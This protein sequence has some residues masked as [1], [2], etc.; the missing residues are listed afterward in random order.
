MAINPVNTNRV[1][2]LASGLETDT[3]VKSM[4]ASYQSR[5]DKQNQSTTKMQ[6]K[7]DALRSVNSLIK[8][9]RES[10]MSVLN[11]SNNMLSASSY[12][13]F[14]VTMLTT[15][16]AVTIKA[17]SAALEGKM[18]IN[19]ITQ[20]AEAA[21]LDSTDVFSAEINRNAALKDLSFKTPLN[22]D[23][24][25]EIKF[26]INGASF[27][28]SQDTTLND[29]MSEI[30][31]SDAG[32]KISYSSLKDGFNIIS[33]TTGSASKIE[34]KNTSGN[35]FSYQDGEGNTV[36]GAIGIAEQT[37][38]GKD[39]MLKIDGIDV[40][41]SSNT[42]T[43]DGITYTLN[44][45]YIPAGADD[46]GISFTVK[47][48]VDTIVD[49]ISKFVDSYNE[50]VGKLQNLVGESVYRAYAPLT[51]EQ[52]DSMKEADINKW[53]EKAKSGLLHNDSGIQQLLTNVRKAL[54]TT[55]EGTGMKLSDIG[56]TTGAY[57][58]GAKITLNKDKLRTA[59]E[60][61]PD[62]VTSLFTKTSKSTD[63]SV[64]FNESGFMARI[65]DTLLNYTS[66]ATDVSLK[67]LDK[68]ISDAKDAVETLEEKMYT[69]S[70]ALYKKF[71][72]MEAALA[73]LNSQ[74]NWMASMFS[75]GK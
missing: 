66:R 9:F 26:S 40:V 47:K 38:P 48:N 56:L 7:A 36:A 20:L 45:Q 2:G 63:A 11:A 33:K 19:S 29:M 27:T 31:A 52:K 1:T 32:V 28:F 75:S 6:W 5:L 25:G 58:D 60:T 55:V 30:N 13:A 23:A 53:E 37:K 3:I 44:D 54:Y 12:S 14:D 10:N 49:R 51:D 71:S 67:S 16:S 50:L 8:T 68:N 18:T 64:K 74:S 17:G 4:L 62:A 24:N 15:T 39:A 70:E 57:A 73:K 35:L 46:K 59:L 43:I 42:F 65:S 61:N 72:A 69:K 22:F 21:S 41:K 34:I